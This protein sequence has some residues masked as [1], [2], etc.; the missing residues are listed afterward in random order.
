[1]CSQDQSTYFP[2]AEKADQSWKK[3][4]LSQIYEC[5]GWETENFNSVLEITISFLGIHKWEPN[6]YIGFSPV[7]HLQCTGKKE[8]GTNPDE[9]AM[10]VI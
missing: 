5:R 10:G 2:G 3:I 7:L 4:K 6:I 1:M 8:S 9:K